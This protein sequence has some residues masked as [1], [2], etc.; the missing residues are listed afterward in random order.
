MELKARAPV[1][2][3]RPRRPYLVLVLV[4]VACVAVILLIVASAFSHYGIGEV[5]AVSGANAAVYVAELDRTFNVELLD[6]G[7][8]VGAT[9]V[10]YVQGEGD[11]ASLVVT[12]PGIVR[13]VAAVKDLLW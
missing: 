10:L 13:F 2:E 12:S 9:V 6:P 5:Q 1:G 4:A 3:R 7:V 11:D 8:K